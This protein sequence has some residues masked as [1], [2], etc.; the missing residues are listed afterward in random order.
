MNMVAARNGPQ[1]YRRR[2]LGNG[3]IIAVVV[4]LG[5]LTGFAVESV[6]VGGLLVVLQHAG[7]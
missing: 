7:S 2:R 6:I 3:W 5:A 4:L 1:Q